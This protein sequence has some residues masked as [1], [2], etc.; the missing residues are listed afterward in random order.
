MHYK[1][2]VFQIIFVVFTSNHVGWLIILP[3]VVGWDIMGYESEPL[4]SHI[5]L[6]N[7]SYSIMLNY[8]DSLS[9][10]Q[11]NLPRPGP[12]ISSSGSSLTSAPPQRRVHK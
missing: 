9:T 2:G 5:K 11:V 12:T 7:C 3:S 1:L 8:T 10:P 4:P 6:R